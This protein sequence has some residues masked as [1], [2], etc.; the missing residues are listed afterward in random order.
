MTHPSNEEVMVQDTPQ[1]EARDDETAWLIEKDDK[2][3]GVFYLRS[4]APEWT[5]DANRALKFFRKADAEDFLVFIHD[6]EDAGVVEH[7]WPALRTRPSQLNEPK[8]CLHCGEELD[9]HQP[10]ADQFCS[11]ACSRAQP[12]Q[13]T[14][15][16]KELGDNE[17]LALVNRCFSSSIARRMIHV[18]W[19]DGIDIDEPSFE[20]KQ[21]VAELTAHANS[22]LDD[23]M[24]DEEHEFF[25]GALD[26]AVEFAKSEDEQTKGLGQIIAGLCAIIEKRKLLSDLRVLKRPE[27]RGK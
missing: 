19:K 27:A 13:P 25:D 20:L 14:G 4:H 2:R 6:I 21:F 23:S 26:M 24:T 12:P 11:D 16:V 8:T 5:T 17:L 18:T 10:P 9:L 15:D 1:Q 7:M 22:R 3:S